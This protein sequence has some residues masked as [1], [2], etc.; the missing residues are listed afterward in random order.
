MAITDLAFQ[1][2]KEVSTQLITI[3]SALI[4]LSVTF[5]KDFTPSGQSWLRTSWLFYILSILFGVVTLMT[6][7]GT[8]ETLAASNTTFVLFRFSTKLTAGIQ[9]IT[10]FMATIC[11]VTFGWK[12]NL[13]KQPPAVASPDPGA[14]II[15][16]P[17]KSAETAPT[18]TPPTSGPTPGA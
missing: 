18:A 7:T 6:L 1:F 14:A 2:A 10:F 8:L 5:I 4:G 12:H 15:D 9:I 3:A 17:S 11:L 16:L 13:Q